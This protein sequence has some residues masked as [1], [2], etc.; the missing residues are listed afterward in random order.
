MQAAD[1]PVQQLRQLAMMNETEQM[2]VNHIL[3]PVQ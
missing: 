1:A 2:E 3:Q